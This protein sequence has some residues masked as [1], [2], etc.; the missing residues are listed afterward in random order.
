M[1]FRLFFLCGGVWFLTMDS[2]M[3]VL[4]RVLSGFR[5]EVQVVMVWALGGVA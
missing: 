2:I 1:R 5:V 3:W 4:L